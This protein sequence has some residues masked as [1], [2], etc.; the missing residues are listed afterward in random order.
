MFVLGVIFGVISGL[1]LLLVGQAFLRPKTFRYERRIQ[2]AAPPAAV[3][4]HVQNFQAWQAWSPWEGLDPTM[5]RV[6]SGPAEGVGAVYEW[7]GNKKV[8][9]GRMEVKSVTAPNAVNVQLTFLRPFPANNIADFTIV[10]NATG[11][12]VVW[13]MHGPNLFMSRVMSAFINFDKMIGADFEKGLMRLRQVV[14]HASV[15]AVS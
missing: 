5:T 14:E 8:G 1:I 10:G 12:E 13:A 3:F 6:Y 4:A 11:C 15:P 9:A 7:D 2:V